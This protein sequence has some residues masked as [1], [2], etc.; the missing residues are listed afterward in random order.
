MEALIYVIPLGWIPSI[1]DAIKRD[2]RICVMLGGF[3]ECIQNRC[4]AGANI[5]VRLSLH[6]RHMMMQPTISITRPQKLPSNWASQ[7]GD[8]DIP[9]EAILRPRSDW[10]DDE[11]W[12]DLSLGIDP[13]ALT[14]AVMH[15]FGLT[16][17]SNPL[18]K[19][20]RHNSG[21]FNDLYV[22]TF[23]MEDGYP[24][25]FEVAIRMPLKRGRLSGRLE[26]T[27][28]LMSY[29]KF[30]A[31]L[32]VP[33]VFAWCDGTAGDGNPVGAPYIIME[34]LQAP[35][36]DPWHD[37]FF[38]HT[39]SRDF[40]YNMMDIMA[41]GHGALA[42]PLPFHGFGSLYFSDV[43][44]CDGRR[45]TDEELK[46]VERYRIGPLVYGPMVTGHRTQARTGDVSPCQG[47]EKA[48]SLVA[49]WKFLWEREV[50]AIKQKHDHDISRPLV[51]LEPDAL[52]VDEGED[53]EQCTLSDFLQ[54]ADHLLQYIENSQLPAD[55]ALLQPCIVPMDYAMRNVIFND[56][57]T[58]ITAFLDWDDVAILPFILCSMYLAE[59]SYNWGDEE[60][61]RETGGFG[62]IQP[63]S[64]EDVT[65]EELEALFQYKRVMTKRI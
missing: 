37:M 5:S 42:T 46:R 25:Q 45:E 19:L 47:S 16:P 26:T 63:P 18:P 64:A 51:W 11:D 2:A 7:L 39:P 10:M 53:N 48:T 14:V 24:E 43:P 60:W 29:V 44:N 3:T 41:K 49:L 6:L 61:R 4:V 15:T 55:A 57:K 38:N 50:E 28:A 54:T 62:C 34:Y 12:E 36:G 21:G 22:A 31:G 17:P 58:A 8:A 56:D 65:E 32:S 40:W 23:R 13:R 9:P 33:T 27:V 35:K 59:I 30:C 1:F 20:R 52:D